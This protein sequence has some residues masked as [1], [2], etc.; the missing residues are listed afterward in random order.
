TAVA[1]TNQAVTLV[2][3]AIA[4]I[5]CAIAA[6]VVTGPS[7]LSIA[8]VAHAVA[9]GIAGAAMRGGMRAR[10]ALGWFRARFARF[11]R[12]ASQFHEAAHETSLLPP[13]TLAAMIV[14][15]GFQIAQLAVFAFALGI[16]ISMA[17]ALVA[18]GVHLVVMAIAVFVPSQI[19]ASEG[20]FALSANALGTT[21]SKAMVVALLIHVVQLAWVLI[22]SMT[23][24]LWRAVE[25]RRVITEPHSR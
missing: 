12:H 15:R 17:K 1:A 14:G 21:V 25:A 4:S 20:A 8:L 22:G 23:P 3:V 19:G 11:G 13:G 9:L 16:D 6:W 24:I 7:A 18:Q 10:W 2:S 5:P